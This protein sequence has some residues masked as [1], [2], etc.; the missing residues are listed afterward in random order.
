[1]IT[2]VLQKAWPQFKLI[3]LTNLTNLTFF[4]LHSMNK[5]PRVSWESSRYLYSVS[6][7][8]KSVFFEADENNKKLFCHQA[9]N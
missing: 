2:N 7:S 6:A 5:T 3:Y 8:S 9:E 1:M 4:F